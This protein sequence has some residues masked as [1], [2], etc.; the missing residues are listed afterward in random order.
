MALRTCGAVGHVTMMKR[1][2]F[3]GLIAVLALMATARAQEKFSQTV[4]PEDFTATGLGKLSPVERTRLD[5]LIEAYKRRTQPSAD[6]AVM[7]EKLAAAQRATEAAAA[8]SL[9]AEKRAIKAERAVDEAK[10]ANVAASKAKEKE[11]PK[12]ERG[13]FLARAKV[14]LKPGTEVEYER[15]ET[16]LP[17]DFRGWQDGTVF[18]LENGQS[19]QVQG[20]SY[21]TPPEPGP[22]K[23]VIAPGLM[24]SFFLE[25]EGVRQKP[26]VK[27]VGGGK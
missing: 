27:F 8:A 6:T 18:V 4:Q 22:R 19:W 1:R 26:K 12:A 9:A 5:D 16:R 25:I 14:L 3:S 15:V 17:G 24:G 11:Q 23:V 10:A 21:V 20:G 7:A 2:I 13:G